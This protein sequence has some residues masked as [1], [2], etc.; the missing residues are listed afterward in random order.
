MIRFL[1]KIAAQ[2][3][4]A[5]L[6]G[7]HRLYDWLQ[8]RVTRSVVPNDDTIRDGSRRARRVLDLLRKACPDMAP[9]LLGP[10]LDIGAGWIPMIPLALHQH[11]LRN[12]V[13]VDIQRALRPAAVFASARWLDERRGALPP[14]SPPDAE[15][16]EALSDWLAQR[17]IRYVAPVYPPYDIADGSLGLITCW[18]VLQYPNAEAVRAI[19]AEAARLLRPGGLYIAAL[20]LD[21]QYA[22]GDR[23][24]P[25]FHFL[26]YGR[27]T[28]ARWFENP[29]TPL[30]RLR[31]SDHER[32]LHGLPLE[33]LV[34]RVEGGGD[35]ELAELAR[36]PPHRDFASY[37]PADLAATGLLFVLRRTH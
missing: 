24:L 34:W 22:I 7:G 15:S 17:A 2:R 27:A 6:P 11:G 13:L 26:R 32:L 29:F 28:W 16:E 31:P 21:D 33:R 12:Q 14:L 4:L 19:H 3:A 10:H 5:A 25:R 30:N 8:R 36:Q 37:A 9:S 35:A 18:Q 20:H 23:K 1:T